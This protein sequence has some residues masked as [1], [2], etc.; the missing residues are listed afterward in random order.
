MKTATLLLSA[1][2]TG[3]VLF[4]PASVG[5]ANAGKIKI[6]VQSKVVVQKPK[7]KVRIKVKAAAPKIAK[8][9]K[10]KRKL[11]RN[12]VANPEPKIVEQPKLA[13]AA[14]DTGGGGNGRLAAKARVKGNVIAGLPEVTDVIPQFRPD[15]FARSAGT[16]AREA[17]LAAAALKEMAAL[18]ALRDAATPGFGLPLPDLAVEGAGS[19]FGEGLHGIPVLGD[20]HAGTTPANPWGVDTGDLASGIAGKGDSK[21]DPVEPKIPDGKPSGA[22]KSDTTITWSNAGDSYGDV[23]E[24]DTHTLHIATNDENGSHTVNTTYD[25]NWN[26]THQ[27]EII[28][29]PG[30]ARREIHRDFAGGTWEIQDFGR[31]GESIGY[32]TGRLGDGSYPYVNRLTNPDYVDNGSNCRDVGCIVKGEGGMQPLDRSKLTKAQVLP[33]GP[34]EANGGASA[35]GRAMVTANDVLERY[36]EDSR[37]RGGGSAL[38]ARDLCFHSE[39]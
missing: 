11:R 35:G 14:K 27:V 3:L 7:P 32:R 16:D 36:D 29:T 25:G 17:A 5:Y 19:P 21:P 23:G 1:A 6:R 10:V 9:V 13:K 22:G 20:S 18:G 39:C 37:R 33:A 15:D 34:D 4:N 8:R 30:G 12:E 31:G 28:T 24:P 38:R 26:R 2:F